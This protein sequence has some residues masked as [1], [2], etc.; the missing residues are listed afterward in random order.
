MSISGRIDRDL[1]WVFFI[2]YFDLSIKRNCLILSYYSALL[3]WLRRLH[4]RE[5]KCPIS[6]GT[7]L[8]IYHHYNISIINWGFVYSF[9]ESEQDF[10]NSDTYCSMA[11][12]FFVPSY[13]SNRCNFFSLTL[14]LQTTRPCHL[15]HN[16]TD[17][18]RLKVRSQSLHHKTPW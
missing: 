8:T 4:L 7:C 15:L 2:I 17:K 11:I 12:F 13:D 14:L 9:I 10:S 3:E 1:G 18:K 16:T 6:A 5:L